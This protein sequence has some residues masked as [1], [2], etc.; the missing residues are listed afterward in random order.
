MSLPKEK[1]GEV[2]VLDKPRGGNAERADR[3]P[4]AQKRKWPQEAA[5]AALPGGW[6]CPPFSV[7]QDLGAP[8]WRKAHM[9]RGR[10]LQVTGPI[11]QR[12]CREEG[13]AWT[14]QVR[15]WRC[16]SLTHWERK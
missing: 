4:A 9:C 3:K 10:G 8:G 12:Q 5:S 14:Q 13:G 2:L 1:V 11:V 6:H 16:V 7:E 15:M